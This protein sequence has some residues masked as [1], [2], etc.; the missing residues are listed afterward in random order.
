MAGQP[1]GGEQSL[2]EA[3]ADKAWYVIEHGLLI[4]AGHLTAGLMAGVT[5][6]TL[7]YV[8]PKL[9]K[10]GVDSESV[11]ESETYYEPSGEINHETGNE[12]VNQVIHTHSTYNLRTVFAEATISPKK[13]ISIV[14]KA[15]ELTDVD[16]PIVWLKLHEAMQRESRLYDML[17]EKIAGW[18]GHYPESERKKI[19]NE[20]ARCVRNFRSEQL[21]SAE[22]RRTHVDPAERTRWEYEQ[23][24]SVLIFQEGAGADVFTSIKIPPG[25]LAYEVPA[26]ADTRFIYYDYGQPITDPESHL[27]ERAKATR[28]IQQAIKADLVNDNPILDK[29]FTRY[30][31]GKR[32]PVE[33]PVA[34]PV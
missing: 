18:F 10:S 2:V 31:T 11:V 28:I 12:F 14:K 5:V 4:H 6:G 32:I 27:H 33:A 13:L 34:R 29:F 19:I 8:L 20:I 25:L 1:H 26:K 30:P 9:F 15:A 3:F 16:H 7:H 23:D 17:P 22:I 24:M 21:T